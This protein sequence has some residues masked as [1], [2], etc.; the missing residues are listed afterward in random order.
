MSKGRRQRDPVSPYLFVLCRERLSHL[1]QKEAEIKAWK[2]LKASRG[3]SKISHLLFADDSL[4]FSEVSLDLVEV[5]KPRLARFDRASRQN[6][7]SC[8]LWI[9]FSSNV[10]E[11]VANNLSQAAR[12]ARTKDLGKYL[13]ARL[14][15]NRCNNH[16]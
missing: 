7:N 13:D 4:F 3:G 11:D 2:P 1:A 14:I 15:H 8:K 5:I 9:Y 16:V 10:G 12:M 6:V